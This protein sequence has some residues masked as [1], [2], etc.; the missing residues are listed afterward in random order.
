MYA[1][2][3]QRRDFF[4]INKQILKKYGYPYEEEPLV[5]EEFHLPDKNSKQSGFFDKLY[6][7]LLYKP[8]VVTPSGDLDL[9]LNM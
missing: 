9:F 7:L 1:V 5:Y 8:M 3:K 4:Q 2:L 6:S